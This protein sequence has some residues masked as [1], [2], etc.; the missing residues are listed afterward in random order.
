MPYYTSPVDLCF[1]DCTMTSILP[2]LPQLLWKCQQCVHCHKIQQSIS[3]L[4]L[5]V[6][7]VSFVTVN[8]SCS[9]YNL[10]TWLKTSLLSWFPLFQTRYFFWSFVQAFHQFLSQIDITTLDIDT[11]FLILILILLSFFLFLSFLSF[12]PFWWVWNDSWLWF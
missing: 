3:V 2:I 9:W 7:L 5:I 4:I 6:I 11:T 12:L 1:P 10:F 8:Q